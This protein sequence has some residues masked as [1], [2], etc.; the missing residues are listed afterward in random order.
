MDRRENI[1]K[2]LVRIS[3]QSYAMLEFFFTRKALLFVE[4]IVL[5]NLFLR[6]GIP[7]YVYLCEFFQMSYTFYKIIILKVMN[8]LEIGIHFYLN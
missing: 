8:G 3:P 7:F 1:D 2:I 5:L 4:M 6:V